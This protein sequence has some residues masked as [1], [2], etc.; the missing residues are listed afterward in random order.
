MSDKSINLGSWMFLQTALLFAKFGLGY[1]MPWWVLWF[2]SILGLPVAIILGILMIG[3]MAVEKN[4]RPFCFGEYQGVGDDR[5]F[6]CPFNKAC[7]KLALKRR[8]EIDGK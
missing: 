7:D 3:M 6:Y 5:C 1:S 8:M 4:W 2:P